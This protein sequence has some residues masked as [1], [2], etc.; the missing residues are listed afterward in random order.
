MG[1]FC[2]TRDD[3]AM[4]R[5]DVAPSHIA[6]P[7][8]SVARS[9][10][11]VVRPSAT[12]TDARAMDSRAVG[13]RVVVV[14]VD[15]EQTTT[16]TTRATTTTRTRATTMRVVVVG[17]RERPR[18][19]DDGSDGVARE[20][21]VRVEEDGGDASRRVGAGEGAAVA[22]VRAWTRARDGTAGVTALDATAARAG[23]R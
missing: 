5:D 2:T 21:G 9:V 23:A 18:V 16:T 12:R 8:R 6:S 10:V 4:L 15:R 20:R 11:L 19:D 3:A 1:H 13:R 7:G 22:C 14:V 17:A